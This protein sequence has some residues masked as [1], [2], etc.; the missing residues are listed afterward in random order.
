MGMTTDSAAA[1]GLQTVLE[2]SSI[3]M[4]GICTKCSPI[5]PFE[6]E[7]CC[8]AHIFSKQHDIINQVSMLEELITKA[9]HHCVFLPK[10]HCELNMIE[11]VCANMSYFYFLNH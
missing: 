4:K 6:N 10:F 8:L 3:D 2:E 1:K 5:C 9:S 11:M 7:R